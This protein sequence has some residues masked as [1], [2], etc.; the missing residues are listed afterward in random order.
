MIQLHTE[1][2]V[3]ESGQKKAVLLPLKDWEQVLC[4]LE[5]LDDI[6]A[7]DQAKQSPEEFVPLEE[8]LKLLRK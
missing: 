7:Y 3:D 6:R 2:L 5:E 1:F 4:E 8:G